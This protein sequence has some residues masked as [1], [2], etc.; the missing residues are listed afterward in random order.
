MNRQQCGVFGADLLAGDILWQLEM[1][2]AKLL[3]GGDAKGF[4]CYLRDGRAALDASVPLGDGREHPHDV[5]VLMRFFVDALK[6]GL[7]GDGDQRR[8]IEV[9]V[10][11]PREQVDRAGAKCSQADAREA[12]ETP[13]DVGHES[14][15]LLVA[16]RDETYL[17]A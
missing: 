11:Y 17:L 1:R 9:G 14:G 12:S 4:A 15:A 10:G 7:A 13:P 5:N 6:P 3:G 8:V 2:R 16:R